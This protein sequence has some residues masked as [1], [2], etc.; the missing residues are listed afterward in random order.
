MI[1]GFFNIALSSFGFL[2]MA[3]FGLIKLAPSVLNRGDVIVG[4][5]LLAVG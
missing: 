4:G 5:F 1:T 3:Q 2:A